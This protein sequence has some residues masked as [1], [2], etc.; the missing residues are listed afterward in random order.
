[1]RR[2]ASA[3]TPWMLLVAV[4]AA[5]G[6]DAGTDDSNASGG[7]AGSASGS[8]GVSG[9]AGAGKG[10]TAGTAGGSSG[11]GSSGVAGTSSSGGA[12]GGSAGAS[13]SASGSSGSSATGGAAGVA[14]AQGG[15]GGAP[16]GGAAGGAGLAGA[17]GATA[18]TA[19]G[20]GVAGAGGSAGAGG[21]AGTGGGGGDD[22]LCADRT[23][24]ALV[25][26]EVLGETLR[27]WTTNDAFIQELED[28]I[29]AIPER[30][31]L[32][33]LEDGRDCDSQWTFHFDPATPRFV[34][35]WIDI[36]DVELS[37]IEGDKTF[38]LANGDFCPRF[39]HVESVSAR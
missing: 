36:C 33:E 38:Y 9:T 5:C 2:S 37:R 28:S 23:G 31:P 10:G 26:A 18:G 3:I 16:Q 27:F 13:G 17:S 25:E 12:G 20:A 39:M 24:G 32:L 29:G 15:A 19:G 22:A 4:T 14:G 8:A 11:G 35:D 1:M 7:L 21:T 30:I 6:S 34:D